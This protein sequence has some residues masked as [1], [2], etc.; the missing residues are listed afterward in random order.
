VGWFSR[1]ELV[2]LCWSHLELAQR[3]GMEPRRLLSADE[4]DVRLRETY[5]VDP[6]MYW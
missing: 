4:I 2:P 3:Y 5:A 1:D 6:L